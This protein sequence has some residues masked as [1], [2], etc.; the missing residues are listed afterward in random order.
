MSDRLVNHISTTVS[1][2]RSNQIHRIY[3]EMPNDEMIHHKKVRQGEPFEHFFPF[4]FGL[5]C[6]MRNSMISILHDDALQFA[7]KLS[8]AR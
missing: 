8:L 5:V 7:N 6:E 4:H 3:R 2:H 1:S